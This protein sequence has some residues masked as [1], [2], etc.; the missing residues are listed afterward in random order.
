MSTDRWDAGIALMQAGNPEEWS[1][2]ANA[3]NLVPAS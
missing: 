3:S 2:V 1:G